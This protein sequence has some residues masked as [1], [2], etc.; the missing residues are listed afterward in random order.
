M[1]ISFW[2]LLGLVGT[3]SEELA[4]AFA[5]DQRID[6][7]EMLKI[8]SVVASK[9]NLPIDSN[10]QK[11]ITAVV[12]VTDEVLKAAEDSIITAVEITQII[13]KVCEILGIEI[14][15]RIQV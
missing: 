13:V 4:E 8:G 12:E 6:A 15:G 2:K 9:L 7:I 11:V 5:D 10:T 3:L 14:S 1:E